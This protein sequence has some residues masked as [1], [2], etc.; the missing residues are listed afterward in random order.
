MGW[1]G[2]QFHGSLLSFVSNQPEL[3]DRRDILR[4]AIISWLDKDAPQFWKRS[5]L[6]LLQLETEDAEP[7]LLG[8][9]YQWVIE[10]VADGHPLAEVIRVLRTAAF[11]ALDRADFSKYVDRGVIADA[12]DV[13][14]YQEDPLRW[15]FAAQLMLGSD[16]YLEVRSTVGIGE[17]TD[18]QVFELAL[19]FGG[20][21]NREG[22]TNCFDEMKRRLARE[23]HE[24]GGSFDWRLRY[25]IVAEL[26][27]VALVSPDRFT[28]F[29]GKF[30]AEELQAFLAES[31]ISGLR[32]RREVRPAIAALTESISPSVTRCLS[33]HICVLAVDEGLEL[34][35]SELRL[36]T[37][38]YQCFYQT[39]KKKQQDG[40][41]PEEPEAPDSWGKYSFE[42][43]EGVVS[44]YVYDVFFF[45]VIRELW[46]RDEDDRWTPPSRL[47]PWLV[48]A[49]DGLAFVSSNVAAAWRDKGEILVSAVHDLTLSI[50]PPSFGE[51]GED[52]RS[53]AGFQRAL[54]AITEDLLLMRRGTGGSAKLQW[55]ELE[56]MA[57]HPLSG[58]RDVL[59][60]NA[61]GTAE[62]DGR[63][64]EH[65]CA[66][67][68]GQLSD[69]V[70]PFA[71]RATNYSLL[72]LLCAR[73]GFSAKAKQFL[74]QASENLVAYGYH[75]D[76]LLIT[77][78]NVVEA[79]GP[80]VENRRS[81]WFRLAP[82]VAQVCEYTDGD[83]TSQ[84]VAQFGNLLMHLDTK[85][86]IA[87]VGW[88]MDS[89]LYHD[90]ETVLRE[91]V[92][93][94]DLADPVVFS[95]VS[96]LI[97]PESLQVLEDS[98]AAGD[99]LAAELL[100]IEPRFSPTT[101]EKGTGSASSTSPSIDPFR[102]EWRSEGRRPVSA[103]CSGTT[104]AIP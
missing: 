40:A 100:R 96:T 33:R 53:S 102:N 91:V 63:T 59:E 70:E 79:V 6:W 86:G 78:L 94:G 65:V 46:S 75:K 16:E 51:S 19:H 74:I 104:R 30:D 39:F 81:F 5:Y 15:L 72:A 85:L 34:P 13:A 76:M 55:D 42:D 60:W 98:S 92:R 56:T 61:C 24:N 38:L 84:A 99:S 37:P 2:T 1:D 103:S 36:L 27:G 97:D 3:S 66:L 58:L 28:T 77:T 87:Y 88:L 21:D 25:A 17:L 48:G 44:R 54:R 57:S 101:V 50:R 22:V 10:A 8:S 82:V 9:D 20:Q 35:S 31:W 71:E 49:L 29:L 67:M 47:P 7:L 73:Y 93:T 83:E 11:E 64:I 32:R 12:V 26:A 90:V 18:T 62:I 80:Y 89:E 23:S 95:L 68:D 4:K 45:L 69:A 52:R 43:Y 14:S 41:L